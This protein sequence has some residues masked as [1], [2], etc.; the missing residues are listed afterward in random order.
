MKYL[1]ATIPRT[2][3]SL[4]CELL[5]RNGL[6]DPKEHFN[7]WF[8][9]SGF[10]FALANAT[11]TEQYLEAMEA[12]D[13]RDGVFSTKIM[14]DWLEYMRGN[15]RTPTPHDGAM[16][17]TLFPGR[18]VIFLTRQDRVLQAIS[19]VRAKKSEQFW[20]FKD[21]SPANWDGK[22]NLLEIHQHISFTVTSEG[23]WRTLFHQAG[24]TPL[25]LTYEELT[26]DPS[27]TLVR[28]FSH[29]GRPAPARFDITTDLAQQRDELSE[30]IR[31]FYLES[32]E[33]KLIESMRRH[34][35]IL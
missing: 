12:R 25:H 2:G 7:Y 5:R 15:M 16:F 18:P 13:T 1:I 4:L 19:M 27:A 24:I 33:R 28:I 20:R 35:E 34:R 14:A 32:M 30:K 31:R 3:S 23:R 10:C 26:A 11:P 22:I 17:Q 8:G 9:N 29:L 21:E 6:G